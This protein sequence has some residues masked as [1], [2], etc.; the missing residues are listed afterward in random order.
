MLSESVC[1][2]HL[3]YNHF[4]HVPPSY[5]FKPMHVWLLHTGL[6][7]EERRK[8]YPLRPPKPYLFWKHIPSGYHEISW[9]MSHHPHHLATNVL[10]IALGIINEGVQPIPSGLWPQ[11]GEWDLSQLV[12]YNLF[13][14]FF[15]II[16]MGF[17][18][19]SGVGH[20]KNV[21]SLNPEGI[22]FQKI[23]GLW[24]LI[25]FTYG[26]GAGLNVV[27]HTPNLPTANLLLWAA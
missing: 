17:K 24:G 6:C 14:F 12:F 20:V 5:F 4:W 21:F 1:P 18:N 23:Y 3:T 10:Y 9:D 19:K 15:N 25:C 8:K 11:E 16:Y 2:K 7:H 22:S 13:W 26:A 27:S